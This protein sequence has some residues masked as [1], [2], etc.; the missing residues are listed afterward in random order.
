MIIGQIKQFDAVENTPETPAEKHDRLLAKA[1]DLEHK[2]N[3]LEKELSHNRLRRFLP[4]DKKK[5]KEIEEECDE[6]INGLASLRDEH[7]EIWDEI[8]KTQIEIL[9]EEK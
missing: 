8:N 6:I 4:G 7:K 3:E 9:R 2:I 1:A 5:E